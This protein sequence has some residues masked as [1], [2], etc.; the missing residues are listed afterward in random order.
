MKFQHLAFLMG[1]N[2]LWASSFL[3]GKIGMEVFPPFMFTVL[4][5]VV[6]II[7]LLPI[8]KIPHGH[9]KKVFQVGFLMGILH[10]STMFWGLN[11]ADE[12]AP[13]AIVAQMFAPCA[14]IMAVIF[15]KEHVGWRRWSAIGLAFAGVMVIGF[16]P[17]VLHDGFALS[18]VFIAAAAMGPYQVVVRT[19]D[20]V[21]ALNIM[22]WVAIIGIIPMTGLSLVFESNHLEAFQMAGLKE[23]GAVAFQGVGVSVIGHGGV[24]YLLQTYP[25]SMVSPYLLMAPVFAIFTG[26]M[27][28]NDVLTVELIVGGVMVIAGVG[29]ITIRNNAKIEQTAV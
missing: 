14:T 6:V 2:F 3:A 13:V 4:R 28:W 29:I 20:G 1:I 26:V 27:F 8:I 9:W 12:I 5:Y 22:L 16:D 23:W 19:V 15:L 17:K 21:N 24:N 10:Y 7:C 25:V 18:L 11:L